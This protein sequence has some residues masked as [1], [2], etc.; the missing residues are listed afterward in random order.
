[1]NYYPL[2]S[3]TIN[4]YDLCK[5]ID[6]QTCFSYVAAIV[7]CAIEKNLAPGDYESHKKKSSNLYIVAGPNFSLKGLILVCAWNFHLLWGQ[8]KG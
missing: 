1:M 5:K 4:F 6:V 2:G 8:Q 3:N 7:S